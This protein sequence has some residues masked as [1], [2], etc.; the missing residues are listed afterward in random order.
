MILRL[1]TIVVVSI[2][3]LS[4]WISWRY[5]CYFFDTTAPIVSVAGIEPDGWYSGDTQCVITG[6]DDYKVADI[7]VWLDGKLLVNHFKINR[8]SFDYTVPIATKTIP[9]GKHILKFEVSDAAHT[10]HVTTMEVPFNVDNTTLQAAFVKSDAECKVFQGRTLHVQFQV[11]KEIKEAKARALSAQYP[12]VQE[13]PNSLIYE[14]FIPVQCEETPNENLLTIEITDKVGNTVSLDTRFLVV[15]F[16]FKKQN[17]V[18]NADKI[19]SENELGLSIKQLDVD[20]EAV[21]AQSPPYKLWQGAFY[22]PVDIKGIST[23]F[24]TVRTTQE[25]GKYPH[26]AVDVLSTPRGVVWATQ[27][28]TVVLKNRYAHSGNTIAIDHGCGI[29]SLFFH[30]DSFANITVGDKIKK[31]NPVGTLG[32]TGYAS[33]Y[34]LHWEMRINNIPVDPLQWIKIDF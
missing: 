4:A 1:K 9:Q 31:G 15:M 20:L 13:A 34:H 14:C 8:K 5:Y 7:S 3:T 24:G 19:K 17:L 32:M 30:L 29:I 12:C 23:E 16:P 26:N 10:K 18:L 11:N 2:I 28:G 25:R 6:S 22:A 27:S 33:G 21:T